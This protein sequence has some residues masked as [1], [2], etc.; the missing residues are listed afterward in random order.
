M[1]I[2]ECFDMI[3]MLKPNAYDESLKYKWLNTVE[4]DIF[5]NIILLAKPPKKPPMPEGETDNKKGTAKINAGAQSAIFQGEIPD[6][7]MVFE[8]Y[9]EGIDE[10]KELIAYSPFDMLYVYYI[11]A[12]IDYWNNEITSYSNSMAMYNERYQS[13]AAEYRRRFMPKKEE[14]IIHI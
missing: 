14:K 9:V 11:C 10:E 13:F 3:D 8:P 12:Q 7:K 4:K 1:K 2:K 6:H 5:D